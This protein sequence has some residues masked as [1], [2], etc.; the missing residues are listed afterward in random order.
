MRDEFYANLCKRLAVPDGQLLTYDEVMQWPAGKLDELVQQGKIK[1][2][3]VSESIVCIEC[4]E[5]CLIVPDVRQNPE[6][7]KLSG[8]YI[9]PN[10]EDIGRITVDLERKRRWEIVPQKTIEGKL[11]LDAGA[12]KNNAGALQT[13]NYALGPI[14]NKHDYY[15]RLKWSLRGLCA[16]IISVDSL[17]YYEPGEKPPEKKKEE[18]I[19]FYKKLIDDVLGIS[20]GALDDTSKIVEEGLKRYDCPLAI[21]AKQYVLALDRIY[22]TLRKY[23]KVYDDEV[24]KEAACIEP[25][26]T[27]DGDYIT[28]RIVPGNAAFVQWFADAFLN[29]V[30]I[31]REELYKITKEVEKN[32]I[33]ASVEICDKPTKKKKEKKTSTPLL[34]PNYV[35]CKDIAGIVRKRSDSIARSL[36]HAHYPVVIVN[37]KAYCDPEHAAA[38]F[39][40]WKKHWAKKMEV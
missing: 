19:A 22:T 3:A 29:Q 12:Q 13:E 5:K 7:G 16:H 34:P 24:K 6:T 25:E 21:D 9:C 26:L 30:A 40:K 35:L 28:V 39:S 1:E 8:V 23:G 10:D 15:C 38:I 17:P 37:R 32:E 20:K 31:I 14:Q 2:A 36:K 33:V 4:P 27:K 11:S 18:I